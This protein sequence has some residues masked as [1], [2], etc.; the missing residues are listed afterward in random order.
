MATVSCSINNV[1]LLRF[2]AIFRYDS[3]A[4][5]ISGVRLKVADHLRPLTAIYRFFDL[6]DK[7]NRNSL[8]NGIWYSS[9]S[10]SI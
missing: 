9:N 3:N 1:A 5:L 10:L 4:D 7:P 2:Q 6:I 8:A